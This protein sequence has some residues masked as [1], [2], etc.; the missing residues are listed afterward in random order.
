[1][2]SR[3]PWQQLQERQVFEMQKRVTR[4]KVT[5]TS[6]KIH[7]NRVTVLLFK[8]TYVFCYVNTD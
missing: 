7:D 2:T 1:M 4:N 6:C 5:R 3:I 8:K